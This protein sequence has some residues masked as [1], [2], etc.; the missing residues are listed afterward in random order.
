[1]TEY[2]I[3]RMDKQIENAVLTISMKGRIY[4]FICKSKD[5]AEIVYNEKIKQL[6]K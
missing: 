3:V 4:R 2:R 1:M 5:E 6:V